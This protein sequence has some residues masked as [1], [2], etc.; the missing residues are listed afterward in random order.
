MAKLLTKQRAFSTYDHLFIVIYL[1]LPKGFHAE[2]RLA[3]VLAS[4]RELGYVGKTSRADGIRLYKEA[5]AAVA[6]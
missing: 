4:R 3:E 2:I 1:D 6:G 5:G